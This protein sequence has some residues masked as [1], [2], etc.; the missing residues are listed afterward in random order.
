MINLNFLSPKTLARITRDAV[1]LEQH[2]FY[3]TD[4]WGNCYQIRIAYPNGYNVS[5]L[6]M[7]DYGPKCWSV[8]IISERGNLYKDVEGEYCIWSTLA[9]EEVIELCSHI[10]L[11]D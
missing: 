11:L 5:I 4:G 2:H 1:S 7:P 3:R 9:E 6:G 10:Y 8:A